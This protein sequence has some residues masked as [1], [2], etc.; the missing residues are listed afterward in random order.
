MIILIILANTNTYYMGG[1]GKKIKQTIKF[2]K[3]SNTKKCLFI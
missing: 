2:S 3:I 1:Y